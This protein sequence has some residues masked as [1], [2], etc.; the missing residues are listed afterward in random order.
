MERIARAIEKELVGTP[1][2]GYVF[3]Y[4][5][6]DDPKGP[7]TMVANQQPKVSYYW[8]YRMIQRLE[9]AMKPK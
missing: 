7:I 1:W 4:F 5:N 9:E 8:V 3:S 6:A 2:N